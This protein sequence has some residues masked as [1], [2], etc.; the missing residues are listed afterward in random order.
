MKFY[1]ICTK[2]TYETKGVQ[3]SKWL[4]CGTLKVLDDN[5][6]FIEINMFPN[7]TFYVFEPKENQKEQSM[8]F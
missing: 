6:M 8:D 4:K 7:T 1:S 5:K 3:K 2:Q